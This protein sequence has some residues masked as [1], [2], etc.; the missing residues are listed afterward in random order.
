M[1]NKVTW[2]KDEQGIDRMTM[3][4]VEPLNEQEAI[5][6]YSECNFTMK[7]TKTDCIQ[8]ID[9]LMS[10]RPECADEL[11]CI[12]FYLNCARGYFPD[13]QFMN[14]LEGDEFPYEGQR[15]FATDGYG[16]VY[17]TIYKPSKDGT[18]RI[19]DSTVITWMPHPGIYD[20]IGDD[21]NNIIFKD[22][23]E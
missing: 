6:R 18:W 7:H 17:D 23:Y 2:S 8:F 5:Q 14:L 19:H 21:Y 13:H 16:K 22:N 15:V 10:I 20:E 9:K 11:R 1:T 4:D 12:R 3:Q